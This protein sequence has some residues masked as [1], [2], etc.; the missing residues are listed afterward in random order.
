MVLIVDDDRQVRDQMVRVLSTAGAVVCARAN[1]ELALRFA[2]ATTLRIDA[3]AT[4]WSVPH[5]G[6]LELAQRVRSRHQNLAVV[7]TS[8]FAH[9]AAACDRAGA[10]FV[11]KPFRA[12]DL[13][14]AVRRAV[15]W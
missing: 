7:V 15:G 12:V 3:L 13:V 6:G 10:V 2:E 5:L 4:D 14:G 8:G 11:R 1:T 9:V